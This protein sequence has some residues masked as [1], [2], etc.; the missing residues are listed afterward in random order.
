M[1]CYLMIEGTNAGTVIFEL[2]VLVACD[3]INSM[4]D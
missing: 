3:I 4:L 1:P 2:Y